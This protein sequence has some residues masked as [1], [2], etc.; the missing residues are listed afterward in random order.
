MSDSKKRYYLIDGIRGITVISMVVFHFMYDYCIAFGK[1]PGWLAKPETFLWQQSICWSFILISG[2][3]WPWGRKSNVKRGLVLN[4]LGFGITLV[5]CLFMPSEAVW[6]GVL[7]FLGCAVLLMF[8]FEKPARK[9]H[10]LLGLVL[11]FALFLF[12]RNINSGYLG[13]G[14]W[15]RIDLPLGIYK[16]K[17]FTPLGFPFPEFVS[18]DYFPI[19]P[20]MFLYLSGYFCGR[21]FER[22]GE[23]HDAAGI[24]I[25]VLSY[26]GSKTLWIYILHQPLNML[27][28]SLI[29]KEPLF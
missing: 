24:K 16:A 7:N 6:F 26:I 5:T 1:N 20:W 14:T 19:L 10:P 27:L 9:M 18:S 12:C 15:L 22:H 23:W 21:I 17:I 4:A 28:C 8:V 11:S 29:L 2:F 13:F 3:V 25:P